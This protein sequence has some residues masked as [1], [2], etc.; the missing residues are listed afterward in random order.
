MSWVSL[1]VAKPRL[2]PV[3]FANAETLATKHHW[4]WFDADDFH[5]P[6]SK[7]KMERDEPLTDADRLPWL[8][9]LHIEIQQWLQA[10]RPT[11]LACSA[12]KRSYRDLLSSGN[13][14][15]KFIYLK[16]SY[17][18]ISQR[19][20]DRQGHFAKVELLKSQFDTLEEPTTDE[21]IEIDIDRDRD[22]IVRSIDTALLINS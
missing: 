15:V 5:S 16:G 12:L 20:I 1:V 13:P 4:H 9:I 17:E 3:G 8:Q 2:P 19:L 14:A 11:S 10:D 18:L 21:A 6:A 22:E 7:A